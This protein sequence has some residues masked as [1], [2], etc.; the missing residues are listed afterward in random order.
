M[1]RDPTQKARSIRGQ[2]A[3]VLERLQ[4]GEFSLR[5]AIRK[6]PACLNG[7]TLYLVLV[8]S[9]GMGPKTA[10]SVC[11]E[12]KVW[13]LLNMGTIL[14]HTRERILEALPERIK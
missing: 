6:P 1:D 11:L 2:R 8:S 12:A 3:H 13:P 4:R 7:A 9:K 5:E 10:K 14:P